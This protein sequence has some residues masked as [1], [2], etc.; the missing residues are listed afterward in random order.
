[1]IDPKEFSVLVAPALLNESGSVFYSGRGA[2]ARPSD[3]YILGLNPGGAPSDKPSIRMNL[4]NWSN[5]PEDWSAY[6]DEAWE[7][8]KAGEYGMQPRVRH[9][10]KRLKR[11]LQKT[12]ASNVVF[13]RTRNEYD[14]AARRAEL[15]DCCWPVHDAVINRLGIKTI[16]CF[17][18]TA[19]AWVRQALGANSQL[20]TFQESNLRRWTST[21]HTNS[22][23]I[24]VVTLTHPSRAHWQNSDTDPTPLV[25]LA[26]DR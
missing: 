14:L 23:D 2:F 15:L 17:G 5:L 19:G 4:E 22:N 13:V 10:F 12:P 24:C 11:D 6:R 1:M 7:G 18:R 16:L 26:I 9:L 8:C 20:G 3:L 21:A 25:L